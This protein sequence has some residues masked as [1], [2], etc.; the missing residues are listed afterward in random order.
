MIHTVTINPSLD[1]FIEEEKAQL[2][3]INHIEKYKLIAGGKGFNV[4]KV[5]ANL[6]F[7]SKAYGFLSGAVGQLYATYL[8]KENFEKEI[9]W[10]KKE[11]TRINVKL[12]TDTE[13][14][15]NSKGPNLDIRDLAYLIDR[16]RKNVKEGD[17]VILSGSVPNGLTDEVY[18]QIISNINKNINLIVDTH[19]KALINTL[20]YHPLLIKPNYHELCSL[21]GKKINSI[22]EMIDAMMY[23]QR[24]GAK[25]VVTSLGEQGAVLLALDQKVYHCQAKQEKEINSVG[26]GDSLIA[27]FVFT[28][29]KTKDLVSSF[30]VG[31]ATASAKAYMD[32]FPSS[33]DISRVLQNIKIKRIF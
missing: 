8:N 15:F 10:V 23:L 30:R 20:K 18:K 31:V 6:N 28:Y 25:N 33:N 14:E 22:E 7:S 19:D 13:T 21:Y 29:L 16:L 5:L 17:T 26:A 27:G 1:Y 12:I 9:I 3:K 2:G 4:S 24:L 32:G 11:E